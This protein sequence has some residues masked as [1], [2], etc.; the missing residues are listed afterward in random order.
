MVALPFQ[1]T[2]IE[3][4][5]PVLD[6]M[7]R[8]AG[9]PVAFVNRHH[10]TRPDGVSEQ[11]WAREVS[12]AYA[13]ILNAVP[14]FDLSKV[15]DPTPDGL[16]AWREARDF[17]VSL[18]MEC[19]FVLPFPTC[20]IIL[21]SETVVLVRHDVKDKS[22]IEFFVYLTM[23]TKEA[24]PNWD[25]LMPVATVCMDPKRSPERIFHVITMAEPDQ[26]RNKFTTYTEIVD[27][28]VDVAMDTLTRTSMLM[29]PG[30]RVERT[31]A[32]DKLN[33][34][35]KLRK[36]PIISDLYT[37][38]LYDHTGGKGEHQGGT[39]ASPRAHWRRG[40]FRTLADGRK[41]PVVACIVGAQNE[42]VPELGKRMYEYVK[43]SVGI[44][45]EVP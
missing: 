5:T 27:W 23:A 21:N 34:M 25:L 13:L 8:S 33:K 41:I 4:T 9:G 43:K 1:H 38:K 29:S 36:K 15:V 31:P 44:K 17:S 19:L 2:V 45:R 42:E 3:K 32:P 24:Y 18:V 22:R 35:R 39:H 14:N 30:T 20:W 40:H 10:P 6:R 26:V 11:S 16:T 37:V 12:V 28:S 7:I